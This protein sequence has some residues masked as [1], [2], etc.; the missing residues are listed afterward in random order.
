MSGAIAWAVPFF[1]SLMG[2]ISAFGDL[3]AA[4]S[5]PALFALKM[6]GDRLPRWQRIVNYT[7]IPVS[8]VVF[9]LGVYSTVYAIV[10]KYKAE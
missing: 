6:L 5:L 10:E 9:G 7:L 8:L 1:S 3:Q 4:Y 2:L